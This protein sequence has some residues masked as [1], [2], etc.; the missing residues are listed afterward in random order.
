MDTIGS[1]ETVYVI[2]T[3]LEGTR[4]ALDT[5]SALSPGTQ[6]RIVLVLQRSPAATR[7]DRARPSARGAAEAL[8]QLA[9]SISPRPDL[10]SCVCE[11]AVDVVQLFR[12][13]GLVLI[14][15]SI[16]R[17]WPTAEQRLARALSELGCRV[18]FVQLP[19]GSFRSP[20][21]RPSAAAGRG[22]RLR[23]ER[24]LL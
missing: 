8:R 12:S 24:G 11:R 3:S 17:W 16:G 6:H 13:P 7:G 21:C 15:G 4:E 23:E 18:T 2:G 9:S 5:V 1:R 20:F 19:R 10:L 22:R 14:G